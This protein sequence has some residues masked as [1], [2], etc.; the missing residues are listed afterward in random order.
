MLPLVV[1]IDRALP[2]G[3]RQRLTRAFH[4]SPVRIG[5]S[6]FASLRLREPFV[7]EWQAVVRFH[8]ERTTYLDLGSRNPT[9][10]RGRVIERNVE[11]EVAADTDVCIGSL[12]L[13]FE[14]VAVAPIDTSHEPES[15][16][17]FDVG[18]QLARERPTGTVILREGASPSPPPASPP[19]LPP[20]RGQTVLGAVATHG[21]NGMPR[22]AP[23]APPP[24]RLPPRPTDG[25]LQ[26]AQRAY[27]AARVQWLEAIRREL[28]SF[29]PSRR[30]ECVRNLRARHPELAFDAGFRDLAQRAG[31]DALELGFVDVENW[32]GRL[33][34]APQGTFRADQL[35]PTM[36]RAGQLL[37]TFA[38]SFIESR[39]AHQRARKKLGLDK[40]EGPQTSLQKSEDPH[41]VLAYLLGPTAHAQER[42][43]ELRRALGDFAMHQIALLS[44]V[45][46]GARSMLGQLSPKVLHES[47]EPAHATA[48]LDGEREL[49]QVWP[50][51]AKK[52]WRK[53]LVRHNDLT[54]TDH[55][56]RELFGREFTRRYHAIADAAMRVEKEEHT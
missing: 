56:T 25:S 42:S 37:E 39:R 29:A 17:A 28:E 55:F 5:R 33:C 1:H 12:R 47:Q 34:A 50:H 31:V 19:P 16:T 23:S 27:E 11:V 14:R 10:I 7:S 2:D 38:S 32:L 54:Q 18:Q 15:D 52:L 41:A 26:S 9:Q 40:A 45:V 24:E 20:R 36:E 6:P 22:P 4:E 51:T 8:G 48:V 3:S 35:A 43:R 44:A 53:F 21:I 13:R 46:E 49:A 30:P